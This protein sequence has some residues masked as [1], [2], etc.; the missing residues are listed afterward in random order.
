MKFRHFATNEA[1][2]KIAG[3]LKEMFGKDSGAFGVVE[4]KSGY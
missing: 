2:N 3:D 1:L 4:G